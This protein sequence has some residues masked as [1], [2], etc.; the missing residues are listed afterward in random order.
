VLDSKR[1][2]IINKIKAANF[3][4]REKIAGNKFKSVVMLLKEVGAQAGGTH[5]NYKG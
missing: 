4:G 3:I 5:L 1:A 2:A